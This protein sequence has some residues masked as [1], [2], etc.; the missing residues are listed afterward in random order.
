MAFCIAGVFACFGDGQLRM[1]GMAWYG[2]GHWP[3]MEKSKVIQ[4]GRYIGRLVGL[5]TFGVL[6]HGI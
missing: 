6:L 1:D 3:G 4:V 2:L 5:H